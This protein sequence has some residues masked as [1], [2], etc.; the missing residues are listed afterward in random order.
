MTAFFYMKSFSIF[1][2]TQILLLNKINYILIL[3]LF[4]FFGC[5]KNKIAIQTTNISQDSLSTYL[6]LANDDRL[7]FDYKK[8]YNQKALAIIMSQKDDSIN[9]VNLFKVANRYY[10][11][12]DWKGYF[13]TSKLILDRSKKNNDSVNMAKAYTYLGDYYGAKAI[14]DSAY[15]NY[16]K[17]EKLYLHLNDNYNLAKT[18]IGKANLQYNENDYF[19]CEIA[20]TLGQ[21]LD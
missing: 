2:S 19:N 20:V 18:R 9:K 6:T 10:N 8:K 16:F 1:D 13:E 4:I 21:F 12:K 15:F 14:S 7:P 17:A 5:T 11:M 3:S